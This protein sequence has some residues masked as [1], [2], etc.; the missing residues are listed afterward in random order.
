MSRSYRKQ[1]VWK[2]HNRGM[3]N[4]ANRHVRRLLN[5]DP[6]LALPYNLYKKAFCRYD[7]C[8][9]CC[10][11]PRNFEQYYR[12]AIQEWYRWKHWGYQDRP[13]PTRKE[14]YKNWLKYRSK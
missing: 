12:E 1:P 7:I 5:R 4:K 11:V 14:V 9:Y 2:D 3:K 10:L 13:Y 6:N 8:D